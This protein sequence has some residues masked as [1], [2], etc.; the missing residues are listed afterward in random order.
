MA[1]VDA[2][3]AAVVMHGAHVV[4]PLL[5]YGGVPVHF[6]LGNLLFD[7]KKPEMQRSE[8]LT[9]SILGGRTVAHANSAVPATRANREAGFRRVHP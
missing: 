9:L 7:Q 3:A 8:I 4:R 6:G 5:R 2:G 1:A